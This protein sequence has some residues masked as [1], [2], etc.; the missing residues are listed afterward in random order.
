M[1][2]AVAFD[3]STGDSYHISSSVFFVLYLMLGL[4]FNIVEP[5]VHL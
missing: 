1:F 2:K 4:N 5:L 3:W